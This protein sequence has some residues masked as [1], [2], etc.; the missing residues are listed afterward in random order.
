MITAQVT[1]KT[2]EKKFQRLDYLASTTFYY[3]EPYEFNKFVRTNLMKDVLFEKM[4]NN[5]FIPLTTEEYY[6]LLLETIYQVVN[7]YEDETLKDWFKI[8]KI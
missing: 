3:E 1:L 7:S 5:F 6:G 8:N 2:N 4:K